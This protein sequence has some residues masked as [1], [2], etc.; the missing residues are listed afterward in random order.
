MA[1][2]PDRRDP[3]P[4]GVGNIQGFIRVF[5]VWQHRSLRREHQCGGPSQI[6]V[7]DH[8]FASGRLDIQV[9]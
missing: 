1:S 8:G 3:N 9:R 4:W 7:L 2:S 5:T 6:L